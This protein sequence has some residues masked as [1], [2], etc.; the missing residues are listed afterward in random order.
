MVD[1]WRTASAENA[2]RYAEVERAVTAAKHW[3]GRLPAPRPPQ[4]AELIRRAR[5]PHFGAA[6]RERGVVA[7]DRRRLAWRIAATVIIALGVGAAAWRWH[8]IREQAVADVDITA[9]TALTPVSLGDGTRITLAPGSRLHVFRHGSQRGREVSLVGRA[10]FAVVRVPGAPFVVH[11]AGGD[12]RDLGTRF[13]VRTDD[14]T[15]DVAVF[16]GRVAL[17]AHGASIVLGAGDVGRASAE[18][19]RLTQRNQIRSPADWLQAALVFNDAPMSEVAAS[20]E[21]QFHY[22]VAIGDSTAAHRTVSAWFMEP[23]SP[24]DVMAAA[25]RAVGASCRVGDSTAAVGPPSTP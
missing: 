9:G 16:E 4:A 6:G 14:S 21:R 12:A 24:R 1:A 5:V 11:T 13:V 3:Y 20:L 15:T 8:A 2:E 18:S 22:R 7:A 17:S 23:P 19:V 10:E 25:C